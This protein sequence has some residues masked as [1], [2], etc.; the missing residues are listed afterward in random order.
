MN[1]KKTKPKFEFIN[2]SPDVR[3]GFCDTETKVTLDE[4]SEHLDAILYAFTNFL[5]ACGFAIGIS[6][7]LQLVDEFEEEDEEPIE[8]VFRKHRGTVVYKED[9]MKPTEEYNGG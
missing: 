9:I 6:E 8:S 3:E 4:G 2:R 1:E 7:T 5:K